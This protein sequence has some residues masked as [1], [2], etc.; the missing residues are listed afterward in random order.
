MR[1]PTGKI[2]QDYDLYTR[3]S[4][5]LEARELEKKL[6]KRFRA[7]LFG[8]KKAIHPGTYR[9]VRHTG[10]VVADYTKMPRRRPETRQINRVHYVSI[11]E[12]EAASRLVLKDPKSQYRHHKEQETLDI[13]SANRLFGKFFNRRST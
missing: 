9:V 6:D 7:D 3:K 11:N 4:P 13:I 1:I 8:V 10:E 5:R 2:T 12:L